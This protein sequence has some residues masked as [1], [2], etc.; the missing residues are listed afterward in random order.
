MY[1]DAFDLFVF[2]ASL[3][4]ASLPRNKFF[5]RLSGTKPVHCQLSIGNC[6]FFSCWVPK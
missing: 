5:D 1:A 3:T 6:P 2:G 4:S